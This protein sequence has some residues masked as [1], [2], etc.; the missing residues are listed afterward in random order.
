MHRLV[1]LAALTVATLA[2]AAPGEAWDIA[3]ELDMPGMAPG[4]VPPQKFRSCGPKRTDAPP[5]TG[6]QSNDE[7]QVSDA[8][9]TGSTWTWKMTCKSG[10]K[11]TGT[12]TLKGTDAFDGKTELQVEGSVIRSKL[13]GKRVGP[14]DYQGPPPIAAPAAPAKTK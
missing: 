10:M 3:L 6:A 14:C 8:K 5:F 12:V 11:G 2:L 4:M 13:A 7:C 1:A 9:K